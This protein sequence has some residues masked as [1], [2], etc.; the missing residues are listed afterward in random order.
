MTFPNTASLCEHALIWRRMRTAARAAQRSPRARH[1]YAAKIVTNRSCDHVSCLCSENTQGSR[2]MVIWHHICCN[3]YRICC[4]SWPQARKLLARHKA[5]RSLENKLYK[6]GPLCAK[7]FSRS[8]LR[9]NSC[10]CMNK[11]LKAR[12]RRAEG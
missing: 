11:S 3:A 9:H 4:R 1:G 5:Q 7:K 8:T 10:P 12:N 2:G 6:K